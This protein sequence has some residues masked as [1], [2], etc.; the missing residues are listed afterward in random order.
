[1]HQTQPDMIATLLAIAWNTIQ[2]HWTMCLLV[3]ALLLV[4]TVA[5]EWGRGGNRRR[6][7]RAVRSSGR[8]WGFGRWRAGRSNTIGPIPLLSEW[9]ANAM[10]GL[11]SQCPR[12]MFVCPQVHVRDF[13]ARPG[14]RKYYESGDFRGAAG[15]IV[16]FLIVDGTGRPRLVIELDDRSH[17]RPDRAARDR[18]LDA[19]LAEARVPILH[20]RP[21]ARIN[22]A[23]HLR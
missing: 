21:N 15:L 10:P 5:K 8:K 4:A 12:G 13:L 1:M 7:G 18:R 2:Q 6:R 22:L 16:D 3:L 20:V 17:D 19:A 23:Q 14:E 9:E 11:L